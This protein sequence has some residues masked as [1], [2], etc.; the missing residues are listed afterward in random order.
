M[1][2]QVRLENFEGPL[3]LLLFLIQENEVDIYDIP[4][5]LI[6]QQ[7]LQ[8][9]EM[10]QL[11]DLEVGSEYLIMAAT[12]LRIKARMLLP[13]HRDEDETEE[14][15]PR[16]ELVQRLVEYRQYKEAAHVLAEQEERRTGMFF[17]PAFPGWDDGD[18]L[19]GIDH[20]LGHGMSLWDL[21]RAFRLVLDRAGEEF[22]KTIDREAISIEDRMS[23]LL[24]RLRQENGFAFHRLFSDTDSR[25]MV[26]VTFLAL[27]ELIREHKIAV[28]QTE[29][30]GD[31]YLFDPTSPVIST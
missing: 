15:D 2:Y 1:A 4:V 23:E 13:R 10:M 24:F 14:E 6:T 21:L 26:V 9:I 18:A 17:R 16:A 22:E 28:T 11:M 20:G 3:D 7:Y 27:L 8:Y 31:I 30:L 19:E 12:L 5:A 29:T 25:L